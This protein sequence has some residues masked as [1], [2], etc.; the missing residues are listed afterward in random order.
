MIRSY[1]SNLLLC[2]TLFIGGETSPRAHAAGAVGG[3]TGVAPKPAVR[4]RTPVAP[5]DKIWLYQCASPIQVSATKAAI[6]CNVREGLAQGVDFEAGNDVIVFG[7]LDEI[8][9]AKPVVASRNEV[10]PNPNTT[11][12]GKL[13]TMVKFPL[14][15][16]FVP[17]GAKRKDGTAHP[18]AGTGFGLSIT[19]SWKTLVP[20]PP[21][22][23][24]NSYRGAET[25]LLWELQQ[26]AFDGTNFKVVT[27]DQLPIDNLLA[28]WSIPNG[29][30]TNAIPDGD[31]MLV[32]MLGKENLKP[33]SDP[34]TRRN[35]AGVL[36]MRRENGKWRAVSIDI[37]P[38]AT[39]L[40]EP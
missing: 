27:T 9:A 4:H 12:P 22:Y 36:R 7:S 34:Q 5:H 21:P 32:A 29:G 23:L 10:L 6:F 13:S 8:T 31:D 40:S 15:G 2:V 38:G 19:Q 39:H 14:R 30:V 37:V 28:G 18:H 25:Y 26:F 1:P 33:G 17:L 24:Q 3:I 11:P 20:G 35:G 16:G